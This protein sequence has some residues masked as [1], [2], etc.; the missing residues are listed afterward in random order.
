MRTTA[1]RAGLKPRTTP[2]TGTTAPAAVSS[3]LVRHCRWE[4]MA[5]PK[6]PLPRQ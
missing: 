4:L 5:Q 3:F 2:T 1:P 6:R